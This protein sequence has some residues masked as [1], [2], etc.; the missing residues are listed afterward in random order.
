MSADLPFEKRSKIRSAPDVIGVQSIAE[1]G[2]PFSCP[3]PASGQE[4]EKE[5]QCTFMIVSLPS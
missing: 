1:L 5:G 2:G 4:M 3:H